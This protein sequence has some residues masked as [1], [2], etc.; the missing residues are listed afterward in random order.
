VS[1]LGSVAS[2]KRN[3]NGND[4]A[5]WRRG[6]AA[7]PHPPRTPRSRSVSTCE[8][9]PCGVAIGRIRVVGVAVNAVHDFITVADIVKGTVNATLTWALADIQR[10]IDT[11][12]VH[13][14]NPMDSV[15]PWQATQV[16]WSAYGAAHVSNEQ[17][18]TN[19]INDALN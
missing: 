11:D 15:I 2:K 1:A 12:G 17:V 6:L 14:V 4:S 18:L 7:T 9:L 16:N 13:A 19:F 8:G 10:Y 3:A 5:H